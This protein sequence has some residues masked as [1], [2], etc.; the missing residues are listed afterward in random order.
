MCLP[1]E[2]QGGSPPVPCAQISNQKQSIVNHLQQRLIQLFVTDSKEKMYMSEGQMWGTMK[3]QRDDAERHA[4]DI[5]QMR[6][7]LERAKEKH[8]ELQNELDCTREQ[9][10]RALALL[11][12]EQTAKII[13]DTS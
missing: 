11:S 9:R 4:E 6:A 5:N 13:G 10:D 12:A 2:I 8:A 3:R 7:R 1:L